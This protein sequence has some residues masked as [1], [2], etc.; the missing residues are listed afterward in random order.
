MFS[1]AAIFSLLAVFQLCVHRT[2]TALRILGCCLLKAAI[3]NIFNI[4]IPLSHTTHFPSH[5]LIDKTLFAIQQCC[6][7]RLS[8]VLRR[9][10]TAPLRIEFACEPMNQTIVS[11][12]F[13]VLREGRLLYSSRECIV[14]SSCNYKKN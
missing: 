8:M 10:T 1:T 14:M 12:G 9:K 7:H 2:K 3:I 11:F 5:P 13:T 6:L 4:Q